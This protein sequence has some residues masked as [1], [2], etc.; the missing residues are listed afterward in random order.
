MTGD[1]DFDQHDS[2]TIRLEG[3]LKTKNNTGY[4]GVYLGG[5]RKKITWRMRYRDDSGNLN[6]GYYDFQLQAAIEYDA[7][8]INEIIKKGKKISVLHLNFKPSDDEIEEL[9]KKG[10]KVIRYIYEHI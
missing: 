4:I 5:K 6:G 1:F 8:K 3:N 2:G 7:V 10:I 9:R